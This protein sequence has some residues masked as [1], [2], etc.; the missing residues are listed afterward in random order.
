MSDIPASQPSFPLNEQV[1]AIRQQ[2]AALAQRMDRAEERIGRGAPAVTSPPLVPPAAP[3]PIPTRPVSA[4]PSPSVL[5]P[6]LQGQAP[7]A[8]LPMP[9]PVQ[10]QRPQAQGPTMPAA[11][12]TVASTPRQPALPAAPRPT[13]IPTPMP[14]APAPVAPTVPASRVAAPV[15]AAMPSPIPDVP[16]DAAP[17]AATPVRPRHTVSEPTAPA[18]ESAQ[19]LSGDWERLIGGKLALWVGTLSIFLA[20]ASFLAYKWQSLPPIPPAGRVGG[21]LL[22][23]L[24]CLICGGVAR[25]RVQRW[26]SEGLSGA[27]LAILYLSIWAGAQYFHLPLLPHSIAFVAMAATTAAG[28]M[29]AVSYDA[30]SL[31]LIATLGGYLTPLL[32]HDGAGHGHAPQDSGQAISFLTYLAVLGAGILAVSLFKRWR[33]LTWISFKATIVLLGAW[34][35]DNNSEA[36]RWPLFAFL[37]LYFLMFFGASCF[38]SLRRREQTAPGDLLLL[39]STVSIYSLAGYHTLDGAMGSFPAAFPLGLA[40]FFAAMAMVTHARAPENRTLRQTLGG[41]ALFGLTIA[42][43]IQLHQSALA[44]GWTVEAAILLILALRLNAPQLQRAGQVVWLLSTLPVLGSLFEGDGVRHVLFLNERALP[45]LVSVLATALVAAVAN[46]ARREKD[47]TGLRDELDS[48]Y[49]GY[50]TLAGAF[51][52]GQETYL[53]CSWQWTAAHAL[54]QNAP[55]VVAM[56]LGIYSLAAF[57]HGI[58]ARNA[59]VRTC[60]VLLV[61]LAAATPV[62][63][64]LSMTTHEWAPFWN[65][66]WFAYLELAGVI[67]GMG[68]LSRQPGNELDASEVE[69]LGIWPGV[70]SLFMVAALTVETYA[71]FEHWRAPSQGSW[72]TAA[73]LSIGALWILSA[74]G[75]LGLG[76]MNRDSALRLL[77]LPLGALGAAVLLCASLS[78]GMGDW[79]PLFNVRS[80][81]F[82]VSFGALAWAAH[83]A[84][85]YGDEFGEDDAVAGATPGIGLLALALLFWGLTQETF[86]VCRYYHAALG[87]HWQ[88]VA[89]LAISMLWTG[90]AS[91]ALAAGLRRNEPGWRFG[92]AVIGVLG[93]ALLLFAAF[94]STGL[95]WTP[96][97]NA[98]FVASAITVLAAW[99]ATAM[100]HSN[101]EKLLPEEVGTIQTIGCFALLLLLG[102][103][104]QEAYETCFYLR[105]ALGAHWDRWAQMGISLVWSVYGAGLLIGGIN[106]RYQPL[107]IGALALLSGTVVKVFL[108]DLGFL[109]GL[110][111]MLSLAGLGVSLIFISFLYSRFGV[112]AQGREGRQ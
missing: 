76:R 27:G 68:W 41:L 99:A 21:G 81:A 106:R 90:G 82:L 67:S 2:L 110:A 94:E 24:A 54:A 14:M 77:A 65:L 102:A 42:V 47:E 56:A 104:T 101:R 96:L 109:D 86:E 49:A 31:S 95:G 105:L 44:I 97:L 18:K 13:P 28:V 66:R 38:Y 111:R 10:P 53:A 43:P 85:A 35:A 17:R 108:L 98:R 89:R 1:E 29:L 75:M 87:S 55:Y 23:G 70:V 46:G 20:L 50:A 80:F 57:A 88:V 12:A 58:T 79:P 61:A 92:A 107:R 71:S 91:F 4:E 112:E 78:N 19:W 15:A 36:L 7:P 34:W 39:F 100:L 33:S 73:G 11:P 84:R 83:D 9:A 62:W 64:S 69:A 51:L 45:L 72:Q 8:P 63:T 74:A 32:L 30:I 3:A 22:A 59:T 48:I 37:T 26:F 25:S 93:S 103:L 60:A 40:L 52:V 16:R 5:P 6:R